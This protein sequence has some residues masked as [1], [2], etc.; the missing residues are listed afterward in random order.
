MWSVALESDLS[1]INGGFAV[2][3]F[4]DLQPGIHARST[5]CTNTSSRQMG[6]QLAVLSDWT[7]ALSNEL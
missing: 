1:S 7:S 2:C 5:A 4:A 3:R 6:E